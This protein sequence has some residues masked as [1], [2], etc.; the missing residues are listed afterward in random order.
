MSNIFKSNRVQV[1]PERLLSF[2]NQETVR[3]SHSNSKRSSQELLN[4]AIKQSES[5][6]SQARNKAQQIN[7]DAQIKAEEICQGAIKEG[8]DEGYSKGYSK[9]YEDGYGEGSVK[10]QKLG[11]REYLDTIE[12]AEK[13]KEQYI[14]DRENLYKSS[15]KHMVMLAVEIARKVIS[16][17]LEEDK[18]AYTRLA[19]GI[20]N[21]IQG[22][23]KVQV[24]VSS[25]DYL[26]VVEDKEFLL[27]SSQGIDDIEIIED[28]FLKNGSCV[29]DTNNG[30]IDG[31]VDTQI[32]NIKVYLEKV[33]STI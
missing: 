20:L 3:Q 11:E 19:L 16:G 6:I 32:D 14:D 5:I 22:E 17:I 23:N 8:H 27:S 25:K 30:T 26:N 18:E 1:T 15:E 10:G 28:A 24:K 9:G 21:K 29:I 2:K 7:I 33:L 4:M 12:Q 13:L 31:G